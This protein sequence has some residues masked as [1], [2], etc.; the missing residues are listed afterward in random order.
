MANEDLLFSK[1]GAVGIITLNRPER[2]N[3][4]SPGIT[5]G[6][7]EVMKEMETDQETRALLVT[8]AGRSFCSGGDVPGFPTGEEGKAAREARD[9]DQRPVRETSHV[10]ALHNC[11]KIIVGAINGYA[12]G[13]GLGLAL[14]CDIRIAAEDARFAVLQPRRGVQP[15][16]GLTYLLPRVVGTQKALELAIRGATGEMFGA[17]EALRLGLVSRVVPPDQLMT[18]AMELAQQIARGPS[19]AFSLAKEGIYKGTEWDFET[20]QEF[21]RKAVSICFATEDCAEGVRSF[22]E[23]RREP[24]FKGR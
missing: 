7:L 21:E 5:Q 3:A 23:N 24:I 18:A 2:H 14:A 9:R 20:S 13:A 12:V 8:G 15:D 4:L 22:M 17:E 19:V 6:I 10:L 1:E 16:G 11:K